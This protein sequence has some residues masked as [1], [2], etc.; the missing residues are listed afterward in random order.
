MEV[1]NTCVKQQQG[2][3]LSSS[4]AEIHRNAFPDHEVISVNQEVLSEGC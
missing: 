4:E 3:V 1:C 2:R